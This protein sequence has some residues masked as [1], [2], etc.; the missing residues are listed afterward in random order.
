M[1]KV[2]TPRRPLLL[3][4]A[5]VAAQLLLLAFQVRRENNVRLIRLWSLEALT[6][7]E[8]A[9]TSAVHWLA[10]LWTGY[11]D[12][13]G[14]REKDRQLRAQVGE[15]QLQ[16]SRLQGQA[17]EAKRLAGLLGFRQSH[18]RLPLLAARVISANPTLATRVIYINRGSRSGVQAN[19]GVITPDGVVG[20][21]LEVSPDSAQVLLISDR[22]SGVGALL[23]ADR[24]QGVA[25]GT[26]GPLLRMDYVENTEKVAIGEQVLTD[27]LDQIFPKDL[28]V[29]TVITATHSSPFERIVVK[30]AAHL[31][32]LEDVLVI[33]ERPPAPPAAP[34][35]DPKIRRLF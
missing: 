16:V 12:L 6:P 2:P 27:G 23:A 31:D 8:S 32:R 13:H 26:G 30:P 19:M 10:G 25:E 21:V 17:A 3:F 18:P 4:A 14:A 35:A 20:K 15:L 5:A 11:L 9:G 33:L 1:M 24:V 22:E 7:V 34:A 28:P 29:G